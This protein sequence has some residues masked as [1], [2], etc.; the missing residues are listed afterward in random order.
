MT[1]FHTA[2]HLRAFR[3][4]YSLQK[5]CALLWSLH[6]LVSKPCCLLLGQTTDPSRQLWAILSSNGCLQVFHTTSHSRMVFS[7]MGQRLRLGLSKSAK[8]E[9]WLPLASK[10]A[11]GWIMACAPTP[12]TFRKQFPWF[13]TRQIN[14]EHNEERT[15]QAVKP[16]S[17]PLQ[18]LSNPR[19]AS[20]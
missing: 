18:T 4:R 10:K 14:V 20:V 17:N 2:F 16:L 8:D 1:V 11:D 19:C 12:L 7:W 6:L 3:T 5:L 9:I 13:K 15:S